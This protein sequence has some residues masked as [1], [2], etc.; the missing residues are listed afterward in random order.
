MRWLRKHADDPVSAGKRWIVERLQF[1]SC[2]FDPSGLK[3]RYIRLVEW[4]KQGGLWVNYWTCT[5]RKV[6]VEK[7][8]TSAPDDAAD[9]QNDTDLLRPPLSA[10]LDGSSDTIST[11]NS[12]DT[13]SST[14]IADSNQD[15]GEGGSKLSSAK[16]KVA[17]HGRHFVVL[18][19]G[20][21]EYLGGWH[22]WENVVITGVND[23]VNAHTGLFIRKCNLEYP[24]LVERVSERI[25]G[26][27]HQIAKDSPSMNAQHS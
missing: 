20:V 7:E 21:G 23:E 5:R 22:R 16:K 1:G 3:E 26:W 19:N 6:K 27:C 12:I 18:P 17:R 10:R 15:K 2:M 11:V 24:A 13:V 14:T 9:T 25:L 8:G 4:E